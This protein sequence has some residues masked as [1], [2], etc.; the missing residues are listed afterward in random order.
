MTE[1]S[2]PAATLTKESWLRSF[3]DHINQSTRLKNDGSNFADWEASLRNAAIAD[4]KLRFLVEPMPAEPTAR[5]GAQRTAY[6]EFAREAGAIKN[7]LIYAMEPN[8]QRRFITQGANKIFTTL[9]N[10]FSQAPRIVKYDSAVRFFEAKLQRGQAVSPHVLNMIENVEK[11]EA[12]G[13]KI[14]EDIVIDRILHSLHEGFTQ[15]RVNYYMNDMKKSLHELHSLLVQAE[16]DLK[17]SGSKRDVLFISKKDKGKG[18]S[19]TSLNVKKSSFN[20]KVQPKSNSGPGR[21]LNKGKSKASDVECH[22]CHKFGHWR[23][24]CPKYKEDIKAGHVTAR[25]MSSNIH[26]IEIN[27]ASSSIWVFDTGCG[28]HLCNHLQGL[29]DV[30]RLAR[31]DIDLRVGNGAKVAAVSVGTYVLKLPSGFELYLRNCYF[32][33]SLSKNIISV[34]MLDIDGFSFVIK[35]NCCTF[36]LNEMVYGKAV[37]MNGIYVLDQT[38][39]EL[40]HV[41]NKRAKIGDKDQTYLWHCRMGHINEKRVKKLIKNGTISP[42]DYESFGTCE[43]CLI[44]KM[45]RISFKGIGMRAADLLGLIHTDVCGPMSIT[46]RDGY[47]YFITFTDDLSRYGYVYLMKHKSESFEKFKE[48]QNKVENQLDRKIKALRSDRGGEYLSDEF[49]RHL[50]GC[51]IV[52][53]LTPPGTPQLNGVSERRNR[54]LLDMVRSMMSHTIVPDSLWGFALNSAALILN[55]SPTK[56]T[57]KTPY[58]IWKGKVPDL[59]FIRVWGCEAYVKWRHEDKL[60]PRAVKTYFVGYPKGMFGHYFYSPTE[61]RVFVAASAK[62]L[63][64]EFLSNKQSSR[65]FDLSEV[66]EPTTEIEM[67]EAVPSTST[68]VTIPEE[69]RRTGRV[70][71]PPDRYIGM[72]EEGNREDILLLESDEPATY[73]G[74]MASSD[75]KLWLEAMQSEIDSMY[76][77]EV[78]DL[79]DLPDKVRPLQCKWLYKIKRSLDGQPDTYKAR[80]VAKGFTQVQG[81][82][83]DE[84][85]APVVMLRSIRII[86]AIAAFHDYEIWQMDVKTAFLN[87]Y[88]EEELYMIQPEGFIDPKHPRKVCKL[89]RS[90]YGLKQASRSWNHRF[91]QVIKE[92]GFKRSVEE[93][94][95]YIK[96]S[97]S[98]I[99]FLILYVDDILLIGNDIPMLSSV[100]VWLQNHFQMKDLGEAQR[101]LGI[102][103]YRDRSKRMLALSQESYIDKILDR[104][105]M[106]NSKRG[107]I[108]MVHGVHLSKTQSPKTPE[109]IERMSRIPY[110]S[111]I[112]SIMYAMMCTRPDVAYALSMTSRYQGNPGESHWMAVKNILKYLRRTKDWFLVYGGSTELCAKGYT[113]ASFQTDRDDSKSQSGFVFTL[114]GAAVSWKSSKQTVT[115]DSTTESEY[116][117]ASEAAKEAIWMRQFL[118]GLTVVPSSNDPIT[119]LCDNSGAIFQAKEPKSSNKSR[120]VL[121]KAHMI[122]DYVE[123][124]E[125]ELCK[126]GTDD[127]ISDPLTKAMPHSKHEGH[128]VAMGLK[129]VPDFQ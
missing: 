18:K 67:E 71:H 118:Q 111:A 116:I 94:C 79:V 16:K 73:R 88:L 34:N 74:A 121:R 101:I 119:L 102:R 77:N 36:S 90:I 89:K 104:F 35:D 128:I 39:T 112:G 27:H 38:T 87:G 54:T 61:H 93:P 117:A 46:A 26:M 44:G 108:P 3:M 123:Q 125:I 58:E 72:V 29:R 45:T 33:P 42:F 37:S 69:P 92:Y 15:F 9:T 47:R 83:Y 78:W 14:N 82:H 41:N 99:A 32:V 113:D 49:D 65:T 120:H 62:F 127:N 124:K 1:T 4:G 13:C 51:G 100:K 8:L 107:F 57:D 106:T 96:S 129:R 81:L 48:F 59:S 22:H 20:K 24:N 97:G 40:Y 28:S 84:I 11:L 55:R 12:L 52:S 21:S 85:F 91:D 30:R 6:D 5:T 115:A 25:G 50:K 7:V 98:K 105:S 110:A 31:G 68:A 86:L 95:L 23:R 56:A 80:L 70:S 75:S 10:E 66:Q 53:Q 64:K 60:G 109:E 43:S 126:V 2:G 17:L 114:N 76:E 19:Q 103:I 63:E 122:R